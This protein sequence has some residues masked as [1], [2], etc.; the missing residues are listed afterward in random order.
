M[1]MSAYS[2]ESS[3][4][5]IQTLVRLS[6]L[7]HLPFAPQSHHYLPPA[8]PHHYNIH[9]FLVP[10]SMVMCKSLHDLTVVRYLTPV[11]ILVIFLP[12]ASIGQHSPGCPLLPAHLSIFQWVLPLP[13][14]KP[15]ISP[16]FCSGMGDHI[17]CFPNWGTLTLKRGTIEI[18]QEHPGHQI[19]GPSFPSFLSQ[20][21]TF[22]SHGHKHRHPPDDFSKSQLHLLQEPKTQHNELSIYPSSLFFIFSKSDPP[23]PVKYPG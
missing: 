17:I 9:A 10:K 7:C 2:P 8:C 20:G 4:S 11:I 14:C 5:F 19:L 23:H 21:S 15:R 22:H 12:L 18:M 1:P 6:L 13:S 16:A 3:P